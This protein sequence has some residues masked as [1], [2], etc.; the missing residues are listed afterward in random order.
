MDDKMEKAIAESK[1]FDLKC[2]EVLRLSLTIE[3][4]LEFFIS[5]YFIKPQIDKTFFFRDELLVNMGF[6]RKISLFKKICQRESF[7]KEEVSKALEKIN[8]V[9]AF[10]NKVAHWEA[11]KCGAESPI[12]LRRK[13]QRTTNKDVWELS[14]KNMEDFNKQRLEANKLIT[15]FH[16]EVHNNGTV[17][18]RPVGFNDIDIL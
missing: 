10:R 17:D 3:D 16:L 11:E 18:E 9:K 15:K 5:N 4:S 13:A 14:D 8:Y 2:G 7:E 6:D 1:D 12:R